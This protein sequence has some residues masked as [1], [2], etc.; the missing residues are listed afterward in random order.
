MPKKNSANREAEKILALALDDTAT[1]RDLATVVAE[2]DHGVRA[3]ALRK[4]VDEINFIE[5]AREIAEKA[6]SRLEKA[7]LHPPQIMFPV[8]NV[9]K[10][11]YGV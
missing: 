6:K 4:L 10:F 2:A 3:A 7:M 9:R 8:A 5:E 11:V 1:E